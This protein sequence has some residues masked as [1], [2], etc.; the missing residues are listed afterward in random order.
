[1]EDLEVVTDREGYMSN[2]NLKQYILTSIKE[3]ILFQLKQENLVSNRE[4]N[5]LMNFIKNS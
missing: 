2:K 1:M 5:E 4:F 3:S